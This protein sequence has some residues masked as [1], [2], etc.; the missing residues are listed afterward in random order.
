MTIDRE[1][2]TRRVTRALIKVV[3]VGKI[4]R[5]IEA[6]RGQRIMILMLIRHETLSLHIRPPGLFSVAP[7]TDSPSSAQ[8]STRIEV[9]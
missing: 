9:C 6:G 5:E 1:Y 8:L 7:D 3:A 2:S 4:M